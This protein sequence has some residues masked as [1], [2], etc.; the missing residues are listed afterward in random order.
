MF[1]R[2]C[3]SVGYSSH[4]CFHGKLTH[5]KKFNLKLMFYIFVFHIFYAYLH[6]NPLRHRLV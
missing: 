6:V 2:V 5:P 3:G 4:R 1:T